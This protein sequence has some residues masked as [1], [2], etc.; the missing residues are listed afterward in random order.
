MPPLATA[1]G[2][3]PMTASASSDAGDRLGHWRRV[4]P[5]GDTGGRHAGGGR[6]GGAAG[7]A[8]VV[9]C[10]SPPLVRAADG[11]GCLLFDWGRCVSHAE[12]ALAFHAAVR[13]CAARLW[14]ALARRCRHPQIDAAE[15]CRQR[16]SGHRAA[17]RTRRRQPPFPLNLATCLAADVA[18]IG[19]HARPADRARARGPAATGHCAVAVRRRQ[20][21]RKTTSGTGGWTGTAFAN[22]LDGSQ[23]C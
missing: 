15:N 17:P 18:Q 5:L 21:V 22:R 8:A 10:L 3:A 14:S 23:F 4:E 11:I 12:D 1:A 7:T 19:G 6:S 16:R 13:C 2:G 9:H 20:F